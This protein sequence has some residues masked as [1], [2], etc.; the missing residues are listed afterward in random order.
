[1]K[2]SYIAA[3]AIAIVAILYFALNALFSG[4]S[5]APEDGSTA[6]PAEQRFKVVV[7]ALTA[8]TRPSVLILRGRSEA[9]RTV[10]VRAETAGAVASAPVIEGS[11][12][13]KGDILCRLS[14]QARQALLDQ[15]RANREAR[16][17]EWGA[18]RTLEEKGHRSANQTASAKA[19]YDAAHAGVRQAEI[20]LSNINIR[21]PFDGIFERRNAEIG[22][23][24]TPGQSCGT[25]VE[26][27]PLI[28]SANVA[29]RDAAKVKQGAKGTAVLISGQ[30]LKG[31]VRYVDPIA[32]TTT[33]TFRIELQTD[34]KDG[35]LHAGITAEVRLEGDAVSAQRIPADTMVLNTK[36]Q[37][38]VRIV[39]ET[40]HARFYP[41]NLLEDEGKGVWV[42]GLPDDIVLIIEG[43]DFVRDGS[44][45]EPVIEP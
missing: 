31:F 3:A 45:V 17:L 16:K 33:R 14:V 19:A 4:P 34:N 42:T 10:S 13:K 29:E 43:Q 15:A 1:M 5:S 21:A 25:V 40:K 9:A 28:I 2:K 39:D 23:F 44:A 37:L 20:E 8:S 30:T 18:A 6:A 36:G 38:G 24:L 27:D 22:D 11:A 32:D 41:I 35:L 26:L 12:V 7:R